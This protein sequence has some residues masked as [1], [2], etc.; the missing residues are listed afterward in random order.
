MSKPA[1]TLDDV[2]AWLATLLA[3]EVGIPPVL[4]TAAA[5]LVVEELGELNRRACEVHVHA[6]TVVV[7]D[8]RGL[9]A[10]EQG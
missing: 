8:L 3:A 7:E 6:H 9:A 10:R 5:H 1:P 2:A 4:A